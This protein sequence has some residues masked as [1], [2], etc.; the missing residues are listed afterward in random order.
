V[1]GVINLRG[2]VV[3]VV[4]LALKFGMADT[5]V[6]KLTCILIV[7]ASLG[8]ERAVVGV[9]ADAVSEVLELA[10]GDIEPTPPFGTQVRVDYLTGMGKVGKGF[11]LL[12]DLDRVLSA[13][14][15]D[16]A[17]RRPEA[18]AQ[19]STRLAESPGAETDG[20]SRPPL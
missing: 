17:L 8:G 16:V 20:G 5:A 12:L 9:I 4:D 18:A 14:E 2:T 7:E 19:L 13:E 3:P 6:T 11:V 1:R 10:A 15:K